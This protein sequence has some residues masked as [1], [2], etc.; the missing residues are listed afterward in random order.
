M[1]SKF[2]RILSFILIVSSLIS[3]LAIFA[4]ADTTGAG[5]EN[6]TNDKAFELMYYRTFNEGWDMKNGMS[7]V[8]QG[9]TGSTIFG[10]DYEET[11]EGKY[12]YF[13]RM[14]LDSSDNDYLELDGSARN[15]IGAVVEFDIM[16]DDVANFNEAITFG[17][18]GSSYTNRSDYGLLK[19]VNNEVYLMSDYVSE[20]VFTLTKQW[21]RISLI[22]DYSY[23][24]VPITDSMTPAEIADAKVQNNNHFQLYVYYGPADGSEESTL[25]GGEPLVLEAR[26]GKGL[27]LIRFQSTGNDSAENYGSTICIDNLAYYEGTTKLQTITSDMGCGS[28]PTMGYAITE[29]IKGGASGK[30]SSDDIG[31]VLC[32]K[33]GVN[34]CYFNRTK[35]A[36]ATDDNGNAYGA[37]IKSADGQVMVPLHM[38]LKYMGYESYVH[39]DGEYID[40]ATGLSEANL[41]IGNVNATIDGETV[42]LSAAPAYAT[43]K[44]GNTYI[45]IALNDVERLFPG[46]YSDYDEM[47]FMVVANYP[48]MLDRSKNQGAMVSIMKEFVF[49]YYTGEDLYNDVKEHTN[50]FQHPYILANGQQID[51]L[52]Q[53]Y[54]KLNADMEAGLIEEG[55]EAYWMWVHYQRIVDTG[56]R[57]YKY[58]AKPDD[59]GGYDTF[60]GVAP[61]EYDEAGNNKRGTY[62]LDQNYLSTS[63]YDI[64]GRSDIMNRMSYLQNMA[65]AYVLTHDIK[66]L[67]LCYELAVIFGEWT[68]W[69]PG[70]FLNCAD[71]S[72]W[73]AVFYDWTYN[74][75]VELADKGVTRLNGEAYDVKVLAEILA[76]QGVH[77]GYLSTNGLCDHVSPVVKI[78]GSFYNTRENNWAAVCVGGMTVAGL[79]VLDGNAGEQYV[80]EAKYMMQENLKSLLALGMDIYA[81]DG[82]YHEGPGYWNYGTNNYFRMCAALDSAAGRNYGLMDCW[83][84]DTTCYY[85][86]H[87]EDN[88]AKFFP[89]H[90]GHVGSQDTSYFFYVA[91]YFNDATLY[92]V[93]LNQINGNIKTASLIDMIY[94]PRDVEISSDAIKLDYYSERI[95]LFAT[96][97]SW[98]RGGLFASMIG[99]K[100]KL[101][102]GQIDAGDFVYHNGGAIWIYDLGTE[103]YNAPGFWPDSTRYK[104]YVMKPEGNNTVAIT[105]DPDAVPYGQKLDAEAKANNWNSNDHGAFV[106]YDMGNTLGENVQSWNRGMLLTNDRKTTVIQDQIIFQ[107]MQTAYWFAHYSLKYVERVE[108]ANNGKTAYM[109]R[110][111]GT[112]EHGER[113]YQTLRL[114]ILSPSS[115]NLKFQ[116]MD[117][118]TFVH[119]EGVGATYSPD[120]IVALGNGVAGTEER[121]RS[122]YRKLAITNG[123]SLKFEVAVVIELIDTET[124]GKVTELELGYEWTDM[125]DWEP[126]ADERGLKVDTGDTVVKR[127]I[128]KIDIHLV[129]SINK[130][131]SIESKG[132]LYTEKL[133]DY[134]RALTDAYYAVRLIGSDMPAG[135]E[136]EI[137]AMNQYKEAYTA[138]RSEIN[139]Y[140]K[141]QY[142][143]TYKLMGLK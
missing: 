83:G 124:Q 73:Y 79:A 31:A 15:D 131:K 53:E 87:T 104:Y 69:G 55:S 129:Q 16:T 101:T 37:P 95:D 9:S 82:S 12:N 121:S 114:S 46:Y 88:D 39:P 20:P 100:N 102:H 117:C 143:F 44:H 22:F 24:H 93:R 34:N 57:S 140:Q 119:K 137:A 33:V 81:P 135:Y 106:T 78:D 45:V 50:N 10:I 32:M 94:Y 84:I 112:N 26:S 28:I 127:G 115:D 139:K 111:I 72:N 60:V 58:Y 126:Y 74:G 4:N 7:H 133:K 108:L 99:G 3:M 96:R 25:L 18:R 125:A 64:G 68:H 40:V 52:Y 21:M 86:C 5:S 90:D 59:Q 132:N 2:L 66:Y 47:G 17:T 130:I 43:D 63:G 134:Y 67:Q 142:N 6:G 91:N 109:K 113:E 54:Q 1:K 107:N 76:R 65:Y 141:T 38:V 71:A 128:P 103:N 23:V 8:D 120:E 29:E 138:F 13:F 41:I 11:L 122:D 110:Y 48:D 19:V 85:A 75:Y 36:I 35:T 136:T 14:E 77:E 97:D 30:N 56:E 51:T 105:T 62:S 49:D 89:Y 27:Q 118:Y 92:D 42:Q 80:K 98:E 123:E 70:H 61:D 116:L